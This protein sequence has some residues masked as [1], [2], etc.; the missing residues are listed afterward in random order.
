MTRKEGSR[1][2]KKRNRGHEFIRKTLQQTP[3]ESTQTES[4][5]KGQETHKAVH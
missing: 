1:Q 5:R 4:R 3:Q 2:E